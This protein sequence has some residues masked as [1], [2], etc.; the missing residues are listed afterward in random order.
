MSSTETGPALAGKA[1]IAAGASIIIMTRIRWID[2][3]ATF[4]AKAVEMVPGSRRLGPSCK[5]SRS[6]SSKAWANPLAIVRPASVPAKNVTEA[7]GE[8]NSI[9]SA[10]RPEESLCVTRATCEPE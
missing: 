9:S 4:S 6:L 1:N 8:S 3:F 5:M 10:I 7:W 2:G